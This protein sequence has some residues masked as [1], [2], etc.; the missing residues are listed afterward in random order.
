M[1]GASK[2]S[3]EGYVAVSGHA[4]ATDASSLPLGLPALIQI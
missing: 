3:P 1:I 4:R 2:R